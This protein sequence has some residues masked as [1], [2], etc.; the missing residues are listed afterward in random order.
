MAFDT[1]TV[2]QA[3]DGELFSA[4]YGVALPPDLTTALDPLFLGV[5]W[6]TEDG[7]VFDPALSSEDA[8]KG[9]PRGEIL[10]KPASTLEPT[11]QFSLAQHDTT[12][13]DWIVDPSRQLS[14]VLEYRATPT[15]DTYRLVLPKVK[16]SESGEMPFNISDL[17]STEITVSCERDDVAGYTFAFIIPDPSGVGFIMKSY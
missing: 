11:F 13:L 3:Y 8:I 16:I 2:L 1:S 15:S 9:W 5:G 4:G 12:T 10:L 6:I 17:I 7:L 14:L